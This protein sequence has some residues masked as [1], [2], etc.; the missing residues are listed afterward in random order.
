[1]SSKIP[2]FKNPLES[3]CILSCS[4]SV[5]VGFVDFLLA[6]GFLRFKALEKRPLTM[7]L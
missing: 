2:S 7:S 3:G 1:M 6:Y 5:E 4:Y